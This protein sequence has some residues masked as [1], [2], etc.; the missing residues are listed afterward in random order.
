MRG[1]IRESQCE[2]DGF[3]SFHCDVGAFRVDS[4][5]ESTRTTGRVMS[6]FT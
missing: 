6:E 3:S 1:V 5:R 4:L 2:T